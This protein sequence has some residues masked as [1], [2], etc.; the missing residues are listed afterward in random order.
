MTNQPR[1]FFPTELGQGLRRLLL[2]APRA[3]VANCIDWAGREAS[4]HL[5]LYFFC[6][7]PKVPELFVEETL[8]E[9]ASS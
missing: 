5:C 7:F 3:A 4:L 2:K 8:K 9:P 6:T 1:H